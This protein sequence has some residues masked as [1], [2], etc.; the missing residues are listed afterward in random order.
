MVKKICIVLLIFLCGCQYITKTS[1]P[2]D[3][4]SELTN[5]EETIKKETLSATGKQE[6]VCIQIV[7]NEKT[8]SYDI[9]PC[10]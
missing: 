10:R 4:E 2:V 5:M 8:N 9:I 1:L 3:K 7:W 6:R